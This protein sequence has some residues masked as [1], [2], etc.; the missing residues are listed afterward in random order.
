[1]SGTDDQGHESLVVGDLKK[2]IESVQS[3]KGA[4]PTE[5]ESPYSIFKRSE[6]MGIVLLIAFASVFSPLSSWIYFPALTAIANDLHTTLS[7]IN[8]TITS[9]MIVSGVA[10][11]LIGSIAD[12]V[13]RRPVY[14][15]TLLTYVVANVGLASQTSYPAL[16]ILRMLQSAGG[17]ATIGLGYG[18]LGDIAESSDRGAYMEIFGCGPNITPSVGPILGGALVLAGWR[19]TFGFLA[20]SG[21]LCL[22]LIAVVLP[23]TGRNIVGNGSRPVKSFNKSLLALWHERKHSSTHQQKESS[24]DSPQRTKLRVPNPKDSIVICLYKDTGPVV[25]LNAVFYAAMNC[26]QASLSSLFIDIYGYKEIEAALIYLPFGVSCFIATLL[27]CK[28]Y[29]RVGELTS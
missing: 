6:K 4:S 5:V 7:K 13:G 29:C 16:L 3:A 18:V 2:S 17:S 27:S 21:T 12:Q 28:L 10:P 24:E 14:L 8:L 15:L 20:I 25:L 19:W 1:M 23:E 22:L 26:L 11:M 9:Y